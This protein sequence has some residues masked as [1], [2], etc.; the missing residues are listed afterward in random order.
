[1]SIP[2]LLGVIMVI[3]AQKIFSY[4]S[5]LGQNFGPPYPPLLPEGDFPSNRITSSLGHRE[6]SHQ[7]QSW[8][9]KYFFRC[10]VH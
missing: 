5:S 7:E 10:F 9:V 4:R 6:A 8:S 3:A 2:H 1:M